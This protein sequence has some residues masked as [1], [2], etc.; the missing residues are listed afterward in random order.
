ML[1][2]RRGTTDKRIALLSHSSYTS[3]C[4]TTIMSRNIVDE[5]L[6]MVDGSG[7]VIDYCGAKNC[8]TC[9]LQQLDQNPEFSNKLTGKKFKINFNVTCKSNNFI[10]LLSCRHVDCTFQYVGMSSK[11]LN[12]RLSGHRNH[13][14]NRDKGHPPKYVG[15]HF[16]KTHLP[17]DMIIKPIQMLKAGDDIKSIEDGWM[18]TLSTVY[19]YGLNARVDTKKI[20]DAQR[21]I[22]NNEMCIY[23]LFK[24]IV[25]NRTGRGSGVTSMENSDNDNIK[26]DIDNFI[27]DMLSHDDFPFSIRTR[28]SQ[29][30]LVDVKAVFL[31]CINTFNTKLDRLSPNEKHI[32]FTLKD[33]S[34]FYISRTIPPKLV[35]KSSHYL[36]IKFANKLVE[37]I[38]ISKLLQ[39]EDVKNLLPV[40]DTFRIPNISYSYTPTIRSK[41][42]NY[43]DAIFS[44]LNHEDMTC[45][46]ENSI[47]KDNNH[48]H[49]VTGNLE[50]IENVELRQLLS[51]G[52][53]YRENEPPNKHKAIKAFSNGIDAYVEKL[54]S[55]LKKPSSYFK[56][57]RDTLLTRI[58]NR[59]SKAKSY[60][61]NNIL[62]KPEVKKHLNS[63][64]QKFVFVPVDKAANNVA[65]ICKKFYLQVL[66]NEIVNSQNFTPS[67]CSVNDLILEH[68]QFLEK[69]HITLDSDNMK[70]PYL[71]WLPKFHKEIVGSRFIT[72]GSSCS[73]KQLSID[74]GVGL[75]FCI[76]AIKHKSNYD[77]YYVEANDFYIIDNSKTVMDFLKNY[78]FA[79]GRKNISTY[80]FQTLYTHIPHYQLKSNLKTFVDRVFTI[81][82]KKFLCINKNKSAAFFSQKPHNK[83]TCF[84]KKEFIEA[85][86]FLIDNSYII[87]KGNL[88]RQIIGI[89]M[90]TNS[91]PHMANIYLH[92]YEHNYIEQLKS[93]H[94]YDDLKRL[95]HIFR[96]QDDLFVINDGGLFDSLYKNIYPKEM[97]LKKTNVSPAVVNFLDSTVSIHQGKFVYKLYDKRNEFNFNVIN[98]PYV[99]GN[100]PKTP[101]HG[102]FIS[103]LIRF[104]NMNSSFK[105]YVSN[106]HDLFTKLVNQNFD[107]L[108]LKRNFDVFCGRHFSYWSKFGINIEQY[109]NDIFKT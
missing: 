43:R 12:L 16:T 88:F 73:T 81:K 102:I 76:K 68:K 71:Y 60:A 8:R 23:T 27:Q 41:V 82:D 80:D 36:V 26:F 61:F 52:L 53:N 33:I 109:K 42:T 79:G 9:K 84:S 40:N 75:K 35:N 72:S 21:K 32:Y 69:M 15:E 87:Y 70:L 38:N 55:L 7:P 100:I 2:R 45:D 11:S 95:Q 56:P 57:W 77:N 92:V 20:V 106:C 14:T 64:Q 108:R 28:V 91:A 97:I 31:Y 6:N 89:P 94:K 44:E 107:V 85:L 25:S 47:F 67:P 90:G 98:Y 66:Q 51:K 17:S 58:K 49:V 4:T 74:L 86:S 10:Y 39:S 103:Q 1:I 50:I 19:P 22:L 105:H 5:P 93:Q 13:L 54:S 37:Y 30:K 101:S 83:L 104:C 59:L 34:Y 78:N 29:L 65:I 63:L 3:S 46:C 99:C 96:Y 18:M 24:E 48:N 62:S